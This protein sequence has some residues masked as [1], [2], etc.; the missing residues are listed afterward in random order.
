MHISNHIEHRRKYLYYVKRTKH[1]R[2]SAQRILNW[3][4]SVTVHKGRS[5]F[6]SG[7]CCRDQLQIPQSLSQVVSDP[8]VEDKL[9]WSLLVRDSAASAVEHCCLRNF[10]WAQQLQMKVQPGRFVL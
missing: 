10:E 7:N 6:A 4:T 2:I 1:E 8:C 3:T 9:F 5:L